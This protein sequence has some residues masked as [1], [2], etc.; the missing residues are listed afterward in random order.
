MFVMLPI[1]IRITLAAVYQYNI[2]NIQHYTI[3]ILLCTNRK[4][5]NQL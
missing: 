4:D 5:V 2:G 3:K 1:D